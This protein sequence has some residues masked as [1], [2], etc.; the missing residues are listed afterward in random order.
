MTGERA[1]A[2][3]KIRPTRERRMSHL[4]CAHV[5][6]RSASNP[7]VPAANQFAGRKS[8]CLAASAGS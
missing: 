6:R 8:T 7:C 5:F 1:K 3:A 2:G 4:Q